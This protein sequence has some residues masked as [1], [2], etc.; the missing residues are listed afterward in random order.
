MDL[1]AYRIEMESHCT[2]IEYVD[3]YVDKL[4]RDLINKTTSFVRMYKSQ[5]KDNHVPVPVYDFVIA[6]KLINRQ[7]QNPDTIIDTFNILWDDKEFIRLLDHIEKT[8]TKEK[9]T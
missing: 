8:Y 9:T 3:F 7:R 1:R 2:N 5:I 6:I 4:L